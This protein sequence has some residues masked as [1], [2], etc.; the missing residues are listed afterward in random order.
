MARHKGQAA[1]EY[2]MTYGW[3]IM[4]AIIVFGALIFF[5]VFSTK[6]PEF[7]QMPPGTV[8]SKSY[9]DSN[10]DR[11]SVTLYNSFPKDIVVV[12]IGCSKRLNATMTC[13]MSGPYPAPICG[14][15]FPPGVTVRKGSSLTF[16]ITC[17]EDAGPLAFEPGEGYAGNINVR[18]YFA[19]E[20]DSTRLISGKVYAIAN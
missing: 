17:E 11:L 6:N 1:M 5:G 7:C 2:L 19:G 18:Y 13:T 15:D 4:V 14:T 10:T 20:T 3:A 8:C 16:N 9:L 12:A